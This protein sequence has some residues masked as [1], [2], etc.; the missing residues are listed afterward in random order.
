MQKNKIYF[1]TLCRNELT[2]A[3]ESSSNFL[4]SVFQCPEYISNGFFA[5]DID[6]SW[7]L[8]KK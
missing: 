7:T 1:S 6:I 4:S 3:S 2:L 8:S 5:L